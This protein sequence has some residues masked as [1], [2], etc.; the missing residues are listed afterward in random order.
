MIKIATDISTFLIALLLANSLRSS[1]LTLNGCFS[2][3]LKG[4]KLVPKFRT[5]AKL[6]LQSQGSHASLESIE[7]YGKKIVFSRLEK[8]GKKNFFWHVSMENENIFPDLIPC[9]D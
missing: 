7:K 1:K 9:F 3:S 5:R 6:G 4:L 8:Y 2:S